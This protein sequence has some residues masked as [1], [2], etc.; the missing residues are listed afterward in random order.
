MTD[1]IPNV[2]RWALT[3]LE[4]P[5]LDESGALAELIDVSPGASPP[6]GSGSRLIYLD[7]ERAI[8]VRD[9]VER[10]VASM[11]GVVVVVLLHGATRPWVDWPELIDSI[12]PEKVAIR[13]VYRDELSWGLA[14]AGAERGNWHRFGIRASE[15]LAQTEMRLSEEL[16]A[17]ADLQ[18][19]LAEALDEHRLVLAELEE[20]RMASSRLDEEL[21]RLTRQTQTLEERW[22]SARSELAS[23]ESRFGDM[24]KL[25]G[26]LERLR[27]DSAVAGSRRTALESRVQQLLRD[28]A[29]LR[30]RLATEQWKRK[31]MSNRRWWLLGAVVAGLI[32]R[33]LAFGSHARALKRLLKPPANPSKPKKEALE[34]ARG[35][36]GTQPTTKVPVA[37]RALSSASTEIVVA[38]PVSRSLPSLESMV[39]AGVLDE[40]SRASF[41][42]ECE[43]LTF[44]PSDWR[45]R[46]EKSPPDLLLVE[47][48]WRG[49]GGSWEY[50]VGSYSFPDSI[51]LPKLSEMVRACRD[52]GIPTVFWNKE[53]PVH[54]E[55]FKEAAVLFD[56]VFTTDSDQVG[57]YRELPG[58]RAHSVAGLPFAAQPELHFPGPLSD[59]DPRPVFAGTFYRNRHPERREQLEMLLDG[60]L[61][62]GLVIY[63]RMGGEV[64]ESFGYPDRF[65]SSIVGGVPYEE[66]VEIY[67]RHRVFL[68]TNSVIDSPTMFSRRVFELLACGTPIVSTPSRGV[69][70][71]FGDI[72]GIV[73]DADEVASTLRNLGDDGEW[74]VSSLRGLTAVAR[75]HLYAD[76]LRTVAQAAGYAVPASDPVDIAGQDG[77]N[78]GAVLEGTA[79]FVAFTDPSDPL[80]WVSRVVEADIL[81]YTQDP[82]LA[83][84]W[85]GLVP[86]GPLVVRRSLL[87]EGWTP[88]DPIPV[89]ARTFLVPR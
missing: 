4:S 33:P 54:F 52:R 38:E 42:P 57:T 17:S 19:R 87:A 10:A 56:V 7:S 30:H 31:A 49:N 11:S 83:Y 20:A 61:R 82:A 76:R 13:D 55:K 58:L 84:Q 5:I 86:D 6:A 53:D 21:G 16:S 81:G 50:Q 45:A 37:P 88:R 44:T 18:R 77:A 72:V 65:H 59:R 8:P 67:R 28:R 71:M 66:M 14:L 62:Q 12:D 27:M 89:G 78:K 70:E 69:S 34:E 63:D 47:S 36:G 24:S 2:L 75:D 73:R 22:S 80:G 26:E 29:T 51:G 68:N 32:R 60:A 85:T 64:T 74:M 9:L 35:S 39:V 40:M 46:F 3:Q 79:P 48:A 23:I 25:E 41:G 15:F 1:S 43:L